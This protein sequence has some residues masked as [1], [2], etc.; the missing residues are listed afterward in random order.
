[1]AINSLAKE[2]VDK[3]LENQSLWGDGTFVARSD[4]LIA[5][6]LDDFDLAVPE[7]ADA[8][9]L[10]AQVARWMTVSRFA[11]LVPNR[12]F[13]SPDSRRLSTLIEL[14]LGTGQCAS[15]ISLTDDEQKRLKAARKLLY[16]VDESGIIRASDQHRLYADYKGRFYVA[17][18]AL[19]SAEMASAASNSVQKIE[20]YTIVVRPALVEALEQARLDWVVIGKK[21]EIE[22]ARSVEFSFAARAPIETWNKW[23]ERF[24]LAEMRGLDGFPFYPVQA[25][26]SD[27]KELVWTSATVPVS[28]G[29][30]PAGIAWPKVVGG[31]YLGMNWDNVALE[32]PSFDY[33]EFE[34]SFVRID[35]PWLGELSPLTSRIWRSNQIPKGSISDGSSPPRGDCAG[36]VMGFILVRNVR[37]ITSPKTKPAPIDFKKFFDAAGIEGNFE[38]AETLA[39]KAHAPMGNVPQGLMLAGGVPIGGGAFAGNGGLSG[40]DLDLAALKLKSLAVGPTLKYPEEL[41]KHSLTDRAWTNRDFLGLSNSGLKPK[42]DPDG[43][44]L[45]DEETQEMIKKLKGLGGHHAPALK[46]KPPTAVHVPGSIENVTDP[47]AV[48]LS[49]M[50]CRSVPRCPDPDPSLSWN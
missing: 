7:T 20:E 33:V 22:A 28:A 44:P 12:K 10:R 14:I 13:I 47:G 38:R 48:F 31:V 40:I 2:L 42:W 21:N 11:D 1:M 23:R 32:S 46:P 9:A 50:L 34:Y 30:V 43:P 27:P 24:K 25:T 6:T 29:N 37:T 35:R 49:G 17:E 19:R 45:T 26:P 39:F 3:F 15:G 41:E 16:V 36:Y 4:R 18:Q 5:W 8:D